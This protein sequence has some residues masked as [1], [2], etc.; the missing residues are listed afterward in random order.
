MIKLYEQMKLDEEKKNIEKKI[1]A[2]K[3]L[4]EIATANK[5]AILVK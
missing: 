1:N 4:D 5:K 2:K 3:M